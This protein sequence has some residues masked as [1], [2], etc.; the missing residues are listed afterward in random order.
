MSTLDTLAQEPNP[1]ELI[2]PKHGAAI[3]QKG[4]VAYAEIL[5][6]AESAF[7]LCKQNRLQ[8]ELQWYLN[9]AFYRGKQWVQWSHRQ[10]GQ[11]GLPLAR[12]IEPAAPT[13]RVRL[14]S[15]QIRKYIRKEH[16]KATKETPTGFVLP[17]SGEE[18]DVF[19]AKAGDALLEYANEQAK[20]TQRIRQAVWWANLT[21]NGFLKDWYKAADP[22]EDTLGDIPMVENVSPFHFYVP[23]VVSLGI[24]DQPYVGQA[25]TKDMDTLFHTYGVEIPDSNKSTND[26]EEKFL[27]V[28][29]I[30]ERHNKK[31]TF[32]KEFWFKPGHS[33]RFPDGLVIVWTDTT[34]LYMQEGWP[35]DTHNGEFP[36]TKIDHIK[37]GS[38]YNESIITDLIPLQK[39]YNRTRSQIIEAKN[40]MSKP[41]IVAPVGSIDAN[42][43]TSEP[44]LIIFYKP[45]FDKPAPLDLQSLPSY[46]IQELERNRVDMDDVSSQHEV[47]RGQAPP[48]VEAATAISYLQE[49]D[50]TVLADLTRSVEAAAEKVGQHFLTY[51]NNHW[52]QERKVQVTGLNLQMEAYEFSKKDLNG[53]TNYKVE[54]G[55]A[56]P[57]SKAAIE[58]KI[59]MFMENGWITPEMGLKY[60]EMSEAGK[61]YEELQVDSRQAQR[62]NLKIQEGI[63]I[64]QPPV[65]SPEEQMGQELMGMMGAPVPEFDPMAIMSQPGFV[66]FP[67]NPWDN[68]T[69]HILEHD[70]WRKR[71]EFENSPPEIKMLMHKHIM[72][73][74]LRL[75]TLYGIPIPLTG[76]PMQDDPMLDSVVFRILNNIPLAPQPSPEGDSD[77]EE[78]GA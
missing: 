54:A 30:S 26:S 11:N 67:V 8:F 74:K 33:K 66:G 52:D 42:K 70:T 20:T 53:N 28:M 4:S 58:A 31:Q 37:T 69:A 50:D 77:L 60:M 27:Q 57:R 49:Q 63:G 51:I 44:G 2:Q 18:S 75:V 14:T 24:E 23:D 43:I 47:S 7:S 6:F 62:E 35:T 1:F 5:N 46:V 9:I 39:E 17:Q 21:G 55:S 78:G 64:P 59:Q 15:N 36:Y 29:G 13:W 45:G 41:Q 38:F 73:H 12:L 56:T 19:A 71:Q 76:N 3:P 16:A 25:A 65:V 72:H 34:I 10:G 22:E 68:D 48:G 61:L 32:V 40:R